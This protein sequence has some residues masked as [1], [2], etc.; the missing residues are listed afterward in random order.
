LNISLWV[1]VA[2]T[3]RHIF[4]KFQGMVGHTPDQ[5][6]RFWVTVTQGQGH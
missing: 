4:V 6:L 3:T 2:E 5:S 1:H